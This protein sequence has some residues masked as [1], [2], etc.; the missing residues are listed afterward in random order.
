MKFRSVWFA[1]VSEIASVAVVPAPP[2]EV[3]DFLADL[4][5][6]WYLVDG[7]V[8]VVSLDGDSAVVRLRGPLG[9]RR[10]VHT[11]IT[12][13]RPPRLLVGTAR[14]G[15]TT[16]ARVIW[17][18]NPDD[19][20]STRV[21]LVARVERVSAIDRLLLAAGGQAWLRRR[22]AFGLARLVTATRCVP[23][24]PSKTSICACTPALSDD[25]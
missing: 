3:F 21:R 6:H 24:P 20:P 2:E 13:A 22:F 17:T 7:Y 8:E 10:I 5:N 25:D 12:D 18:L 16:T 15:A 23:T 19:G 11:Q 14:V 9:V 1:A 4:E